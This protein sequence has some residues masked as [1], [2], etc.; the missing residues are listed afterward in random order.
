MR[1]LNTDWFTKLIPRE[2]QDQF[3]TV[4]QYYDFA[5]IVRTGIPRFEG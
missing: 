4:A 2:A 1:I 5:D 3:E